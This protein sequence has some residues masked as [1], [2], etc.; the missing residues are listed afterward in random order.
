MRNLVSLVIEYNVLNK[1]KKVRGAFPFLSFAKIEEGTR[2]QS[3]TLEFEL[4][5]PI[6]EAVKNPQMYVKLDL[7]ILRGLNSKYSS[8]LYES[9]KDYQNLKKIRIEIDNLRKLMG[10]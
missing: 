4:P 2:G 7:L 6:L 10:V 1:D 9:L 3:T 5:T 8:A